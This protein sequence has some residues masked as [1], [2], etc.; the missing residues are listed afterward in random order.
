MEVWKCLM[1][2]R[3]ILG[4]REAEKLFQQVSLVW[5]MENTRCVLVK[6][7]HLVLKAVLKILIFW[8]ERLK[9]SSS[10]HEMVGRWGNDKTESYG[11][12]IQDNTIKPKGMCLAA[13]IVWK[14]L[15][16]PHAHH[17]KVS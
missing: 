17:H 1:Y 16:S 3:Y 5:K 7:K 15:F 10:L 4:E 8:I 9:V 14:K 12:S 11:I 2:V 6:V 13:Q